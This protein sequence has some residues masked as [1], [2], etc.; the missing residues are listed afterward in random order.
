[1]NNI[2]ITTSIP[3]VNADPHIGFL[4]ELVAADVLARYYRLQGEEVF[5]LAGTDEHGLKIQQAAAEAG[6]EPSEFAAKQS[7]KFEQLAKDFSA[8]NDCFVRTTD[9]AHIAFVTDAW[10]RLVAAGV[11]EKRTYSGQYC[12][13][14]EAFKTEREIEDGNCAIHKQPLEKIEEENYFLA[15]NEDTKEKIRAW[16]SAVEPET[17]RNEILNSL[18]EFDGVSVSRPA[19]KLQWGVPVPDDATQVIYVWVDA[20][21]SYL[22]AIVASERKIDEFWPGTQIV[23]KDI[24]KFHA[25]IW[26]AILI[27][28]KYPLPEKLLVHGFVNVDGQKM[29][30]SLGNVIT[31]AELKDR[32]GVEATRYL[33]LRQL[34]F[35]DDSNFVW[36]EFDA[37]FNGELANGIGN[38]LSRVV[39]MLAKWKKAG[40]SAGLPAAEEV[41]SALARADFSAELVKINELISAAD[42]WISEVKP[43]EWGKDGEVSKDQAENLLRQSNLVELAARLEPFMPE[44]SAEIRRQLKTLE[45]KPLFPRLE[46][47]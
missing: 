45:P 33:L 22:S 13:G 36:S 34:N 19:E 31:P 16:I 46:V 9:E 30:K 39:N 12:T 5:F 32:Y 24:V 43:W 1:M 3:Y 44:T 42:E 6:E 8:T 29:S 14:C 17:K 37:I 15:V 4:L 41:D 23:G 2:T 11:I 28:L 26:P 10:Q 21:L 40:V 7:K 20:L 18:V 27:A 38:L 47:K 25:I 35:Y